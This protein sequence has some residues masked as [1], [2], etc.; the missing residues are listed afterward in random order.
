MDQA[1]LWL[2]SQNI[3][4]CLGSEGRSSSGSPGQPL[5]IRRDTDQEL[6]EGRDQVRCPRANR[7]HQ[8]EDSEKE[9]KNGEAI[10]SNLSSHVQI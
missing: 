10:S 6:N 9:K 7:G 5:G 1:G 2:G 4:S 8:S 3:K